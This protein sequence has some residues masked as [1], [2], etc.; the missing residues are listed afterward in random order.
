[1][2]SDSA[3]TGTAHNRRGFKLKFNLPCDRRELARLYVRKPSSASYEYEIDQSPNTLLS[4]AAEM[5]PQTGSEC[6]VFVGLLPTGDPKQ[7]APAPPGKPRNTKESMLVM[8]EPINDDNALRVVVQIR[9]RHEGPVQYYALCNPAADGLCDA[10]PIPDDYIFFLPDIIYFEGYSYFPSEEERRGLLWNDY[11]GQ[12]IS[13]AKA[14]TQAAFQ[15]CVC[16]CLFVSVT[17]VSSRDRA[18][19]SCQQRSGA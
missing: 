3:T 8:R 11:V 18:S 17:H 16:Q 12:V 7:Y 6:Y 4:T 13:D 2:A 10:K 15:V 19:S 9:L 1:M 5:D 14:E